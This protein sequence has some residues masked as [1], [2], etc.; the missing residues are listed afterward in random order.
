M[1]AETN[2]SINK[3][4]SYFRTSKDYYYSIEGMLN[5]YQLSL[6]SMIGMLK[7]NGE[8]GIICP[9]TLFADISA[10]KLR[11]Y[12]LSKHKV[13]S[14]QYFSEDEPL[15]DNV[16]QAT[17][18]F[19]LTKNE[20]TSVINI[21]NN[22][23]KYKI[24]INDVKELFPENWDIPPI[25]EIEWEIIKILQSI[26]KL[27]EYSY[28]RNKRGEL[29]LTLFKSYITKE[30]TQ[31]RLV[32]GNMLSGDDEPIDINHEYV[33]EDFI[34]LK[35]QDFIINDFG[36][37]RLVCQQISNQTQKK[38]LKFLIC[39]E[40]DILGNSCNYFSVSAEIINQLKVVLN[41]ALLNWR[42][43]I[44][45]SNN[46]INNYELDELP[47]IPIEKITDDII[48]MS[49][50]DRDVAICKLYGLNKLQTNFILSQQYDI[51]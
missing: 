1:D 37:K 35:S 48:Q 30:P 31:Y 21:D 19:H 42:F 5:L 24:S 39:N 7:T 40:F 27:K 38:R 8:M 26:P 14:I 4:A 11:K 47:I 25:S 41:S 18:I 51:I 15:F 3:L 33:T 20:D 17:C 6:E 32:R 10:S 22:G 23:V 12:M 13:T 43:K 44:T 29:D 28:I 46:H 34:K 45:S 2:E 16:T 49:S 50:Y 9:S 36:H